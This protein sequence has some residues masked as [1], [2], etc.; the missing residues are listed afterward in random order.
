MIISDMLFDLYRVSSEKKMF[1]FAYSWVEYITNT[2][3]NNAFEYV[4]IDIKK[5]EINSSD[6][7]GL[8]VG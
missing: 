5:K 6:V 8:R 2:V 1:L 4:N 3:K 7:S